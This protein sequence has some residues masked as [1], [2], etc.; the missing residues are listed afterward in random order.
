MGPIPR[1]AARR[2]ADANGAQHGLAIVKPVMHGMSVAGRADSGIPT[3]RPGV[4]RGRPGTAK[5]G[6]PVSTFWTTLCTG[7]DVENQRAGL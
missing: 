1:T 4:P 5:K 2:R 3:P 6:E 7:N